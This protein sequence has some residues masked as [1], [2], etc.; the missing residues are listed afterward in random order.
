[1]RIKM[2]CL[3]LCLCM[4]VMVYAIPSVA[5]VESSIAK[6]DLDKAKQQLTEVLKQKPDSYVANRYMAEILKL[7]YAKTGVKTPAYNLYMQKVTEIDAA[8]EK[9][10]SD[11]R[12]ASFFNGLVALLCVLVLIGSVALGGLFLKKRRDL[13][14]ARQAEEDWANKALDEIVKIARQIDGIEVLNPPTTKERIELLQALKHDN[15]DALNCVNTQDYHKPS[16]EQHIRLC[17]S[18]LETFRNA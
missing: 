11:Q 18:T 3:G 10:Q 17:T 7:E 5:D 9:R 4:P 14:H 15:L 12:W 8:K 13:V 2:L 16:I 1:M 6:Q